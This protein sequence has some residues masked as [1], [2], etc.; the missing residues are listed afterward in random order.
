MFGCLSLRNR[1][2]WYYGNTKQGKLQLKVLQYKTGVRSHVN[3]DRAPGTL[4]V[5]QLQ[6]ADVWKP[7]WKPRSNRS[8]SWKFRAGRAKT[9]SGKRF[10]SYIDRTAAQHYNSST[11]NYNGKDIRECVPDLGARAGI[12]WY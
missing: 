3:K 1:D 11:E 2:R 8:I 5:G 4:R 10:C 7:E 6:T 9:A 12:R